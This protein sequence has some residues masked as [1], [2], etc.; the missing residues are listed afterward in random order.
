MIDKWVRWLENLGFF[1]ERL[2]LGGKLFLGSVY[3]ADIHVFVFSTYL[4]GKDIP[5]VAVKGVLL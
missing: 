3:S 4:W 5:R 2:F 1:A